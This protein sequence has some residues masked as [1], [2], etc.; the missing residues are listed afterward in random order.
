MDSLVSALKLAAQMGSRKENVVK[1][2][3]GEE[4]VI[5]RRQLPLD[6]ERSEL[7]FDLF[8]GQNLNEKSLLST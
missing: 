7:E 8:D 1:A 6:L 5:A 2:F 3:V 4:Q